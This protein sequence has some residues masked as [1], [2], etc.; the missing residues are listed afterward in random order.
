MTRIA[1]LDRDGVLNAA[2]PG[3]GR[4]PLPPRSLDEIELL[5][6]VPEA[7]AAL[8]EAGFRLVVATNQPDVARGTQDRRIVEAMNAQLAKELA[9]DEVQVCWHDDADG[10]P[11]RKP[12]A[13]LLFDTMDRLG[14]DPARCVMV[15]DRWRD[16]EAGNRAGCRTA[17]VG[18]GY[19]ETFPSEPDLRV[20]SLWDAASVFVRSE[21]E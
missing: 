21:K 7:C 16:I 5:P 6:R 14:A 19:G 13:G 9:I 1:F 10:C 4:I 12:Q 20:A 11:C 2:I 3:A 15:G 17:L 8:R 18:D